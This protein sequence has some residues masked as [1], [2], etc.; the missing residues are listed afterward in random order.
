MKE[1]QEKI[2]QL[3]KDAMSERKLSQYRLCKECNVSPIQFSRWMAGWIDE[4]KKN[5]EPATISGK[6][7]M[8]ILCYLNLIKDGSN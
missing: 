1:N 4:R 8:N 5:G 7:I 2:K 6:H 3:I